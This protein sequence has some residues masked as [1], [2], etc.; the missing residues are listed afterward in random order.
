MATTVREASG[1]GADSEGEGRHLPVRPDGDIGYH[2]SGRGEAIL[3]AHAGVFSDWFRPLSLQL[4]RDRF[5][6]VRL[7]R[8]GYRGSASPSGHLTMADHA[9][10]AAVLLDELG[11]GA[12]HWVG[13]SSSCLIGLQLAHDRPDLVA[14]LTLLEPA[15]G[16]DLHGPADE[17][18]VEATIR[19]AMEAFFAGDLG[20]AFNRFMR[21]I[22]G[23]GYPAVLTSQLGPGGLEA[24][25]AES[26]FFFADELRAVREWVFGPAQ[27]ARVTQ[28]ALVVLG[29]DSDRLTPLMAETV[30]QLSAL[31]PHARTQTLPGCSHLMPLQQAAE[32]ARLVT[33][34]TD[35]VPRPAPAP[36]ETAVSP[37]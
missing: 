4:P 16:G 37:A 13:H 33:A 19:P 10:H 27:A 32:L 12:A 29:G 7:R 17:K 22:G 34:F 36:G 35:T 21:G 6:V 30:Q 11:I 15:P 8:A 28:P 20:G 3:L 1:N 2:D 26:A 25:Q 5:R 14:S 23:P 24:A 31:L 18:F 9:R